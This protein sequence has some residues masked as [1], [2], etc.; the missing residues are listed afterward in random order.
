MK[1]NIEYLSKLCS[2]ALV[3][4]L[5]FLSAC[6]EKDNI[7]PQ[8]FVSAEIDGK[9]WFKKRSN[10]Y[11]KTANFKP[12]GSIGRTD[13]SNK[14]FCSN[15]EITIAMGV[16]S[17]NF[18]LT[19]SIAIYIPKAMLKEGSYKVYISGN[20]WEDD[21]SNEDCSKQQISSQF[22]ITGEDPPPVEYIL[23]EGKENF[24][25][26]LKIDRQ[27]RFIEGRFQLN[28]NFSNKFISSS[29]LETTYDFKNGYFK[30]YYNIDI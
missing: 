6:K 19:E 21:R 9:D 28:Y 8:G 18:P 1:N 22:R 17:Q 27:N 2:V 10:Q 5:L 23:N 7:E 15:R 4:L 25:K 14:F 20:H 11:K 16:K 13:S 12:V 29:N 3:L 24:L 26:I 30:I